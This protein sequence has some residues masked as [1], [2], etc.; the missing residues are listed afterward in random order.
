MIPAPRL[1]SGSP[2][3]SLGLGGAGEQLRTPSGRTAAGSGSS[4]R[5][6]GLGL[7]LGGFFQRSGHSWCSA[8]VQAVG[9]GAGFGIWA[10]LRYGAVPV[11]SAGVSIESHGGGGFFLVFCFSMAF[12][13]GCRGVLGIAERVFTQPRR[14]RLCGGVR[15]CPRGGRRG[16][17]GPGDGIA[18]LLLPRPGKEATSR[19]STG[20]WEGVQTCVS[21]CTWACEQAFLCPGLML[22]PPEEPTGFSAGRPLLFL[23]PFVP[24][25]LASGTAFTSSLS[26]SVSMDGSKLSVQLLSVPPVPCPLFPAL[27]L[28]GRCHRV[29]ASSAGSGA[30]REPGLRGR[31]FRGIAQR[32]GAASVLGGVTN[33]GRLPRSGKR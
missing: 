30:F 23:S 11:P 33:H 3:L 9:A 19:V 6:R 14:R 27:F 8:P 16:R 28:A 26:P 31:E 1:R 29:R 4:K 5:G 12:S 10:A 24:I 2:R 32:A 7:N 20:P 15:R 17:E 21:S 25:L 18:F 13:L 22:L